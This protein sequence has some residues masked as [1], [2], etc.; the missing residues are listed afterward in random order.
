MASLAEGI[1]CLSRRT[2]LKTHSISWIALPPGQRY[3]SC[4]WGIY[5]KRNV[6][7][8]PVIGKQFSFSISDK[9]ISAMVTYFRKLAVVYQGI[10]H[11]EVLPQKQQSRSCILLGPLKSGWHE[12]ENWKILWGNYKLNL[13]YHFVWCFCCSGSVERAIWKQVLKTEGLGSSS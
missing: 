10:P 7:D 1:P 2:I 9:S 4:L 3:R 5:Y 13:V 11:H 12:F 8:L 6:N